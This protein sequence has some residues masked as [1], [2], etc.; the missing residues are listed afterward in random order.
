MLRLGLAEGVEGV[1][2]D[3]GSGKLVPVRAVVEQIYG[4]LA[5]EKQ[6]PFGGVPDRAME[7][8]RVARVEETGE[9]LGWS[10]TVSLEDGLAR[11]VDW[12]RKELDAGRLAITLSA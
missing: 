5:P 2:V 6:P 12:Y 7:P 8:V 9:L 11:T 4:L 3:L 10:P 1:Q